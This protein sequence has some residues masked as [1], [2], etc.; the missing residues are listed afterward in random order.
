V[1]AALV[2]TP[3]GLK[4]DQVWMFEVVANLWGRP[5]MDR[6]DYLGFPRAT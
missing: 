2:E 5:D 1:W 3:T 6:M 4:L